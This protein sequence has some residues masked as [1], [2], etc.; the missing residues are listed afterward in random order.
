MPPSLKYRVPRAPSLL[1]ATS[2]RAPALPQQKI[3]EQTPHAHGCN[4]R[5]ISFVTEVSLSS[6]PTAATVE[7]I[8]AAGEAQPSLPLREHL[9]N[10][11]PARWFLAP[12]LDFGAGFGG[13]GSKRRLAMTQLIDQPKQKG[14]HRSGVQ[15][16]RSASY[17][18]TAEE[19]DKLASER[20]VLLGEH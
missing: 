2:K 18:M 12:V 4:G 5:C 3:L 11:T 20:A 19:I 16:A 15:D 14:Q 8:A 9:G 7:E 6:L 13:G 1:P 10:W 17:K